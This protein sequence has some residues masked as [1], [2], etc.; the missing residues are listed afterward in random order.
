MVRCLTGRQRGRSKQKADKREKGC[1]AGEGGTQTGALVLLR[2]VLAVLADAACVGHHVGDVIL[3]VDPVQQVGH[4]ALGKHGHIL[5]SVG[6]H[7][8]RD[9][10]LGLVVI[11]L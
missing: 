3:L 6:L 8:Q 11:F 9:S 5:S 7:A 1:D 10:C 2:A 4:G